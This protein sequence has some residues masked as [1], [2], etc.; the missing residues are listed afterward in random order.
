[1][2]LEGDFMPNHQYRGLFNAPDVPGVQFFTEEHRGMLQTSAAP[3][4]TA[5]SEGGVRAAAALFTAPHPRS[6]STR[7]SSLKN[8]AGVEFTQSSSTPS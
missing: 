1:M 5:N 7:G 3:V 6:E 4:P 8:E 2:F